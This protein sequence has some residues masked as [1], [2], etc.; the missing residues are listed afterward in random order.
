MSEATLE[1][2]GSLEPGQR[3]RCTVTKVIRRED[4]WQTVTRLMRRDPEIKRALK[5]A[6]EH[7]ARTLVVRSRGGRPWPMHTR[8]AKF[9]V[10]VQGATWEMEY[11]PL[12]R[13]D[14]EAIADA[15]QVEVV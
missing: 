9:A 14:V 3:I 2:I 5:K 12:L 15:V 7:R 1:T 11:V 10:P 6:Q 13:A 4:E 8:P